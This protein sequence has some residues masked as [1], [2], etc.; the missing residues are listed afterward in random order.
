M[1]NEKRNTWYI[2][3]NPAAGKN[4]VAR[5]WQ[6]LEAFLKQYLP[7]HEVA[8][9]THRAHATMLA[10]EAIQQGYRHIIAIGG[11]GTNFEVING[12]LQQSV[13]PATEIT[14]A[15]LP[16]GTGN[17]WI[18]THRIP[19]NWQH[20]QQMLK[21]G[22]TLL[23]DV[24][25]VHY[26]NKGKPAQRY[27]VNVAGLAYDA[28]VVQYAERYKRWII[29]KIL[30]L[31]MVVRCLFKYRLT[32]ARVSFNGQHIEDYFYTIN[33]GIGRYSG[34]GMRLVPHADPTDG[35]LAL[36]V[37]RRV[38][39]LGVLLNTYRFYNGTLGEHPQIDLY[40]TNAIR[41]EP[42]EEQPLW[43]EADGEFLG[44]TP[45]DFSLLPQALKIIVP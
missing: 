25:V 1:Q 42:L 33:A 39:K 30:Y 9:T 41:V 10:Q 17:D 14:Y 6:A 37:A 35:Q 44:D 27:F 24:G 13:V 15:L 21:A 8:L 20:W 28:F 3:A 43:V 45:A 4:A 18:R 5:R 2:I 23:Q 26:F 36:T 7:D 31:F 34:G 16:V 29:H 32:R 22:K 40:Q 19:K 11:D 38:S 12:I